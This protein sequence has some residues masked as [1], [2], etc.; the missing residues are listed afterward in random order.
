M[1]RKYIKQFYIVLPTFFFME[2][3]AQQIDVTGCI[4]RKIT[5]RCVN[6]GTNIGADFITAVV[7]VVRVAC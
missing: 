2:I 4:I 5:V 7:I 3:G 1:Y 6:I